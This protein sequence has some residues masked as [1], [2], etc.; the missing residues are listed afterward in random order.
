MLTERDFLST[1]VLKHHSKWKANKN[2]YGEGDNARPKVR[3][4]S[5]NSERVKEKFEPIMKSLIAEK[6]VSVIT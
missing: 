6:I 2:E 4:K 1:H 5:N 3:S